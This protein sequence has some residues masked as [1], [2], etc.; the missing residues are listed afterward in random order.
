MNPSIQIIHSQEIANGR[1]LFHWMEEG[2]D[3]FYVE[4]NASRVLDHLH[5]S[6]AIPDYKI[7]H[8]AA[9]VPHIEYSWC[10]PDGQPMKEIQELR[11]A[12]NALLRDHADTVVVLAKQRDN[13][14]IQSLQKHAA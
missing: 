13:E 3:Q 12:I 2:A 1:Y 6:G 10:E 14:K 8:L 5:L 4:L 9:D 11:S 7:T